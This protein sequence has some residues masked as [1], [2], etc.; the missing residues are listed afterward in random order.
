MCGIA[1]FA[2]RV[3]LDF[4][5]VQSMCRAIA[6]RGPD[7]ERIHLE[8]E[9]VGL[10][11][12]RLSIIDITHG[13]QPLSSEDG[14]VLVTCNGEI[15][16][17]A[18]LREELAARGHRFDTGSDC[19]VIVHLWEDERQHLLERLRGMFAIAL[20]DRASQTLMLARDRFGVK[21]LYWA[22]VPGGII[23]GSEPS[24]LLAS[25]LVEARPDP[26]A[27]AESLV[28]QY[29]PPPRTGFMGMQKL[30]PG[31][32][33]LFHDGRV[34]V[35]RW[36]R[37][38]AGQSNGKL[39]S[40]GE[41]LERVDEAA[42]E[43]TT[44]R[45]VSEVPLGAFLSGGIDSSIVVSYMAESLGQVQT[46]S[47][48]FAEG[49][50]SE[51]THA[52]R[53]SEIYGTKHHEFVV[54]P[55]MVPLTSESVRH[56]G[57]PYADSSAIPTY[58]L[59]KLTKGHVTVA[60]SGDGGDEAFG[61]YTRYRM[62]ARADG[63]GLAPAIAGRA[64]RF[65]MP[66]AV[67]AR[68]P[69]LARAADALA[70][71]SRYRYASM[72]THFTPLDLEESLTPEFR[73]QVSDLW[74]P[75]RALEPPRLPAPDRYQAIDVE[76]YL[77]G[78]LLP[79]VDRMSMTH[80]LEVRSPFL[81]HHLHEVAFNLP[82]DFRMRRGTTKWILKEL[83]ARR[84]LPDDLVHRPKQGFGIPVGQWFRS[85][86]RS[87]LEDV[88]RDPRTRER[89]IFEARSVDRLINDHV[90]RRADHTPRLWNLMMLEM[91]HRTYIDAR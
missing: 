39:M 87:W 83:A 44:T 9:R 26:V 46:F 71:G 57:E 27:I 67:A 53:V 61:G 5:D 28:L 15:Y 82:S 64:A 13:S 32:R 29:V 62:A 58:L 52:R 56:L 42:R 33:L 88:L 48:D 31:E 72:M 91:W 2:G 22:E 18:V 21:P 85:E 35:D 70:I 34:E 86:L 51:G 30:A 77:P 49:A 69:R 60:L 65:V 10:G 74:G 24:A 47:I 38:P 4:D 20:W 8:P 55:N 59:S 63:W 50:F 6:H 54:E 3:S 19:E 37:P 66:R 41:A 80:A 40:A 90:E 81:D 45:L 79:K 84:G 43:A 36:W 11:F 75:W 76:S 1:G 68:W 12:R 23:Y 89:G 73:E 17:F 78:D 25:A 7:D 14:G 16:N